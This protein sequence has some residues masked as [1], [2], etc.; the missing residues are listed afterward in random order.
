MRNTRPERARPK[1]GRL[2]KIRPGGVKPTGPR[3]RESKPGAAGSIFVGASRDL[4]PYLKQ[5][6]GSLG[7]RWTGE[8]SGGV[9]LPGGMREAMFLNLHLRIAHHVFILLGEFRASN[10]DE[11]YLGV[12][13]VRWEDYIP[14]DGYV[15]VYSI[16]DTPEVNDSRFVNLKCKDAIVDRIRDKSGKR[17]DSGPAR[18]RTVVHLYWKG[19]RCSIYLDT[20]GET[21]A[22]R[23]YRK[24]PLEAPMKENLAAAVVLASGFA[25][26]THFINPMC[27]SGT[28]AIEAALLALRHASGALRENF[29]FMHV[30]GFDR[31]LW[32]GMKREAHGME[33]EAV[34][35]KII[36]TDIDRAAVEAARVNARNAGVDRFI[37]IF[38]CDFRETPIPEGTGVVVLNPEYGVRM[39][40]ESRLEEVYT[41]IGDF[42]KAKCSGYRGYVFSG[43]LDLLKRV[44]LRTSK[45]LTFH[46]GEIECRLHEYDLYLGTKRQKFRETV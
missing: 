46:N 11:L 24:V 21:L 31:R 17:P 15:C 18:D 2:E 34:G 40:K 25:P 5:E 13:K 26:G 39:G 3:P 33:R 9:S 28:L 32:E 41:G 22:K 44:G 1:K 36:A 8:S 14:E 37:E 12:C 23:S 10:T 42:F 4:L 6:L 16:V 7:L 38:A 30:R 19:E 45:R 35:G 27:G 20:S 43:N 29:G